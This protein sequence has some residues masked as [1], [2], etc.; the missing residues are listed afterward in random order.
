M[1]NDSLSMMSELSFPIALYIFKSFFSFNLP[2]K[3]GQV[4]PL[5]YCY[6]NS[7]FYS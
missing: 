2:N 3:K 7:G 4:R 5:V 1:T 6:S